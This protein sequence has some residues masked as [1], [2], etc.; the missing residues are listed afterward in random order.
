MKNQQLRE[1]YELSESIYMSGYGLLRQDCENIA[2]Q[3]YN[4]GY[5]KQEWISVEEKLPD[6]EQKVIVSAIEKTFGKRWTIMAAHIGYHK[7]TTEEYGWRDF[8]GDTEYDEEN[9][10][11]WIPE[12]WY[13]TNSVDGNDNWIIDDDFIVT[14]W[15]P[16]PEAPKG[17]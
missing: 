1:K 3:L 10:C 6:D 12:C 8:E 13:E 17:E 11:F 9:D 4:E 2:E 14:H 5:R 16:L 15:M 7:I